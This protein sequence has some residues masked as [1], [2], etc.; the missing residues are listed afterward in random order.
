MSVVVDLGCHD[1]GKWNSLE[2]LNE[3][4]Q[5]KIIYGFDPSPK[6]DTS[7][8][9]VDGTP[10]VL[11]RKAAWIEDGE[12]RFSDGDLGVL[13]EDGELTVECFDFAVWLEKNG[14]CAVK[15]DIEGA[16]YSLLAHLARTGAH[17]QMSYLFVEWH[18]WVQ[19][20][21]ISGLECPV[22]RWWL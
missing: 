6:L 16:E 20:E 22:V 17:K 10:V 18:D 15:M 1:H 5:P 2:I 21:L 7:I 3:L 8:T 9:E 4:F 14:P 12:A 19:D 11:E 13:R